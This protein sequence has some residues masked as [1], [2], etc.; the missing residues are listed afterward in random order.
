[1]TRAPNEYRITTVEDFRRLSPEQRQ[2]IVP[3]LLH[4]AEAMDGFEATG[5]F[6]CPG[7]LVWVDDGKPGGTSGVRFVK[8]GEL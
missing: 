5:L 8:D 4:W 7:Y 1:M 6:K 3:D 2:R